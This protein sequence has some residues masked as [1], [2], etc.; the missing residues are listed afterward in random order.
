MTWGTDWRAHRKKFPPGQRPVL[1][2]RLPP[3]PTPGHPI[4]RPGRRFL[5]QLPRR[6]VQTRLTV[7]QVHTP[8]IESPLLIPQF[9][10]YGPAAADRL[11][12][13][14][15]NREGLASFFEVYGR[16][17]ALTYGLDEV[18]DLVAMRH[19]EAGRVRA[20]SRFRRYLT[21]LLHDLL[22]LGLSSAGTVGISFFSLTRGVKVAQFVVVDDGR[23]P[24][25]VHGYPGCQPG[26][27][28][29]RCD[30]GTEG[31]A[32]ELQDGDRCVFDLD[33]LVGE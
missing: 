13:P 5:I 3:H 1:H 24:I 17:A 14:L 27:G 16:L 25:A 2:V 32:C 23:P 26:V 29:R 19:R 12:D 33:P 21:I 11:V 31:A 6:S 30:D 10:T 9:D 7:S 8:P 4:R 20:G 15:Y 18:L 22:G 28:G